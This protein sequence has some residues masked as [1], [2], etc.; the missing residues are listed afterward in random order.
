VKRFLAL[1]DS[2]T[3]GEGVAEAERWPVHLC[4]MLRERGVAVEDPLI[5]AR[6]AWTTDELVDAIADEKPSGPFDLVSLLVG[7]NDQY[8]ARPVTGFVT[9]FAA[10]LG[11][12]KKFARKSAS[13]VVV[14]SIPDWGAT[15][16]GEGR[17][18]TLITREIDA[19]NESARRLTEKAG[20]NWVDVTVATR[21]MQRDPALA[22][23]DGLHPSSEM[24]RRWAE[25]VL[26]IAAKVL[27]A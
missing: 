17:D 15:P 7:V 19:Y 5:F 24:Y 20:S 26:P 2:Y 16:F 3:I 25:L 11:I 21:A 13:R 12:A 9:E 14:L 6:T 27:A 1:G 8:R 23:P 22:A 4:V 10:L 18:R